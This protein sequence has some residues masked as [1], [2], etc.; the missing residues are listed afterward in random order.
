MQREEKTDKWDRKE[1]V[2]KEFGRKK[3]TGSVDR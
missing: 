1:E 2:G 3:K